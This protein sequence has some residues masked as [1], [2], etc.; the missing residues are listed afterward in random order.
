[1]TEAPIPMSRP[2]PAALSSSTLDDLANKIK[3][4]LKA[5]DDAMHSSIMRAVEL[6]ELLSRAKTEIGHGN[7]GRW[8][9]QNCSLKERT[10]QRYMKL[11]E[12]RQ[13]IE[14]IAKNKSVNVSDLTISQAQRLLS[15][16]P[17]AS[18]QAAD[19]PSNVDAYGKLEER[20]LK[21]LRDLSHDDPDKAD[22]AAQETIKHLKK[23]V[24]DIQSL[25]SAIAKKST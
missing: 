12:D 7:W 20:L 6:G 25:K 17:S 15:S 24:A 4:H 18:G 13:R 1:M 19:N 23:V 10:A 2:L 16:A 9:E 14:Q 3:G 11:A 22:T 21:K 5:I 8:L